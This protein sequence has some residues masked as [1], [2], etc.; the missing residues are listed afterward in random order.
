M[1][2]VLWGVQ[3]PARKNGACFLG[4]E[5]RSIEVKITPEAPL[6]QVVFAS[7]TV[8]Y[9]SVGREEQKKWTCCKTR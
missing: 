4:F 6:A 5:G 1:T 3:A 2:T 9:L 8:Q 7:G